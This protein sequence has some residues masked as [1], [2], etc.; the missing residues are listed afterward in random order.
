MKKKWI[1]IYLL[2]F[3][4]GAG[5]G[6]QGPAFLDQYAKRVD[7][8]LIE[9]RLNFNGFVLIAEQLHGGSV[10]AL[11]EH[12]RKSADETFKREADVIE[13]IYKRVKL[14]ENENKS[15]AGNIYKDALHV[16]LKADR[17]L[18]QETMRQFSAQLNLNI[19]SILF[20]LFAGLIFCLVTK[21]L[22]LLS[23][24]LLK[25]SKLIRN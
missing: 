11:I 20:A 8:H 10:E 9:A 24:A 15:L 19:E 12:H 3:L 13:G 21:L 17:V 1:F 25:R 23:N 5:L 14:L 4:L 18:V 7:A 2:P 6:S 22:S 16:V